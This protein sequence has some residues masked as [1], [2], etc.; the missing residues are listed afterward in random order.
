MSKDFRYSPCYRCDGRP[1]RN[2][3]DLEAVLDQQIL[4]AD[5]HVHDGDQRAEQ[6]QRATAPSRQVAPGWPAFQERVTSRE[7]GAPAAGKKA[8][9]LQQVKAFAE[10]Y[11]LP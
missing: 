8:T 7:A 2:D 1:N 4:L 10:K 5:N 3:L 9:T 6:T 11:H